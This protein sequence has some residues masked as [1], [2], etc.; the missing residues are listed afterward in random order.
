MFIPL[1]PSKTECSIKILWYE[2]QETVHA[3]NDATDRVF[4]KC[5]L[6][7]TEQGAVQTD[8]HLTHKMI[9]HKYLMS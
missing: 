1:I 3:V 8:Q 5:S 4:C 2:T 6:I 7:Y 9:F